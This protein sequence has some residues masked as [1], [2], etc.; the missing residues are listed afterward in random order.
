MNMNIMIYV[1]EI[2]NRKEK[3]IMVFKF[4]IAF[5]QIGLTNPG[6]TQS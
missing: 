5:K 3:I 2:G 6:L 4:R 1:P